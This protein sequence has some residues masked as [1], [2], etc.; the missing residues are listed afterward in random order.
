[1]SALSSTNKMR[2]RLLA[3][4]SAERGQGTDKRSSCIPASSCSSCDSSGNHRSASSTKGLPPRAVEGR[5]RGPPPWPAG[6]WTYRNGMVRLTELP[7]P[8]CHF[9]VSAHR[10][11][12]QLDEFLNQRQTD[13][14]AF[15]RAAPHVLD[16]IESLE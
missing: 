11:S 15:M 4:S 9:A 3:I 13:T 5:L 7:F 1:M 16:A 12:L 2:G 14:A 8:F 10:S 6:R